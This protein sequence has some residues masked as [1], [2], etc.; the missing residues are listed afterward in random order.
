MNNTMG[1]LSTGV[2][3]G[4]VLAY[5]NMIG[6]LCGIIVGVCVQTNFPDISQ[7][8]LTVIFQT[9]SRATEIIELHS[10]KTDTNVVSKEPDESHSD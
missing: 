2:F 8:L 6:F 9:A 1:A 10:Y 4:L 3:I 7:Y 5:S